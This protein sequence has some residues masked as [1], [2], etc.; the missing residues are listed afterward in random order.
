[1]LSG[2]S[3]VGNAAYAAARAKARKAFL[4]KRDDYLKMLGME[5]SEIARFIGESRYAKGVQEFGLRYRGADLIEYAITAH[6]ARTCREVL[7]FCQGD[8]KA[9]VGDYMGRWDVQ[10]IKTVLRGKFY[11][12]EVSRLSISLI[13]AGRLKDDMLDRMVSAEDPDEVIDALR[14]TPYHAVLAGERAKV[15]RITSLAGFEDALD[16]HYY[17]TLVR[18]KDVRTRADA[19]Y[20][21][22]LKREIDIINL[23]NI[24]ELKREGVEA[25]AINERVVPGGLEVKG[26]LLHSLVS[27]EDFDTALKAMEPLSFYEEV[28]PFLETARDTLIPMERTLEKYTARSARAF[29]HMDPLSALPVIDYILNQK[30]EVDNIRIIVRAKEKGIPEERIREL[31]MLE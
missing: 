3:D 12:E 7:G 8:L 25:A 27:A 14:G 9:K 16:M 30:I 24:L 17:T 26:A 2:K 10:N 13:R 22:F 19:A 5:F 18:R 1:M 11:G 29:S 20:L 23:R 31:I 4:L 21:A 6:L 15:E 28:R